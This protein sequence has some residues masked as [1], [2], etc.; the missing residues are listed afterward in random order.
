MHTGFKALTRRTLL[1]AIA[2]A[3]AANATVSAEEFLFGISADNQVNNLTVDSSF[4]LYSGENQGWWSGTA[5]NVPANFNY[6][7]GSLLSGAGVERFVNNF[8]IFD[9]SAL[10]AP[11]SS[12]VLSLQ[13]YDAFSGTG[14]DSLTYSLFDV[15]TNLAV[16]NSHTGGTNLAIFDDLGSGKS[17]GSFSISTFL[18][19]A[20]VVSLDLNS[21]GLDDL[22]AAI[23][24][25][26]QHFAIG[27]T[28]AP[29][30]A[31]TPTEQP[32]A[33]PDSGNTMILL[34]L[35]A[36]GVWS[37]RQRRQGA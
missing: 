32:P 12:A 33:V 37:I 28:L 30:P 29:T 2:L 3:I 1:G 25:K 10:T 4:I 15:S 18:G 31:P 8:F 27:G 22:N 36:A 23:D 20:H 24:K 16:L 6:V 7:V 5:P 17:Y 19:T 26:A 9:I 11:V 13:L 34:G 35:A 14:K 21:A